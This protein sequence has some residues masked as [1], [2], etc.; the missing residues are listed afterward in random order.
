MLPDGLALVLHGLVPFNLSVIPL[1]KAVKLI[2]LLS[3]DVL[4]LE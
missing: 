1:G 3:F 4:V 2:C